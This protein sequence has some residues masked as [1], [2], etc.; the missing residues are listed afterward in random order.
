MNYFELYPGDYLRDTTRLT[1]V[2]HGAYLR[3]LMAYY[4]E[5][6]PLPADYAELYV[7]V[8]AV[9]TADKAAVRKVA[10]RFFAVDEDGLRRNGRADGEIE[11]AQRRIT[12]ARENGAKGGRKKNPTGNPSGNP[13][14]SPRGN[15]AGT[16]RGTHSGE[17]L[18]TP[19]AIHHLSVGETE[20][21]TNVTTPREPPCDGV[22]DPPEPSPVV[23][24]SIA[25]RQ[26]GLRITPQHPDLIAAI[27]EGVTPQALAAMAEAYPDKPAGY[28][29]S[30]CRRQRAEGAKPIAT[31]PPRIVHSPTPSKT[32]TAIER[33]QA[34]KIDEN[35]SPRLAP[36]RDPRRLEQAGDPEL[37]TT[38]GV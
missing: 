3:L 25:L 22:C 34:L 10:D 14:G 12:T 15:P 20:A 32:R 9:S 6:T 35:L 1:L 21:H 28:V 8:S 5:E 13:T 29:I 18:Q 27:D 23:Q 7:I 17:A 11:K 4:A 38:T 31:G 24:A 33:L 2:E 36:E 26:R 37:G 30:A 19:H 16:Q